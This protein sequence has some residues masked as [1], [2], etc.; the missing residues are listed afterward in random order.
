MTELVGYSAGFLMA[1]TM[2]P[3]I[4]RSFKTKSVKDISVSMLL[5][6]M[7]SSVLWVI[8]GLRI[9]ALPVVIADGLAFIVGTIQFIIKLKFDR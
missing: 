7:F 1:S 5:I 8:Y 4:V 9:R 2:I 3:Q 6:Y